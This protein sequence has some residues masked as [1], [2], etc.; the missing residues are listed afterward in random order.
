[1]ITTQLLL[2]FFFAALGF[3]GLYLATVEGGDEYE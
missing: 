2:P 1:M 3:L